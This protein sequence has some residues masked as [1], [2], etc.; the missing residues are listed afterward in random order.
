MTA[1]A[2]KLALLKILRRVGALL[3]RAVDM[4]DVR[5]ISTPLWK[6]WRDY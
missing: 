1:A 4:G 3:D 2:V 6:P 5:Y